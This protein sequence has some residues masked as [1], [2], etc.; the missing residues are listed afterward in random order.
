MQRFFF[1]TNIHGRYVPFVKFR[2]VLA[3]GTFIA[4]IGSAYAQEP[5][6]AA[7]DITPDARATELRAAE[8]LRAEE[9][10]RILRVMPEFNITD[11]Q[12]AAPL[13]SGQKF[14]LALKSDVDPFSFV[15]AGI[16][17][18]IGQAQKES[19]GYGPGMQGYAK[20]FQAA[21]LDSFDGDILGNA[22]FPSLLH[23]DPRYF[24]QGTGSFNSRLMH[25]ISSAWR[26]KNDNGKWTWNYSNLLGNLAAGG[27]ANTYYASADRGAAP[28][29][30]RAL[31][32]TAEG[33]AGSVFYEFWPDI[34]R[35]FLS[36]KKKLQS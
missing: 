29:F 19:P 14:Q 35:K 3:A 4:V 33:A 34:S 10:Q 13:S 25:A 20:R 23:Q 26:C 30:E 9:S 15:V 27:I 31:T 5:G 11:L 8:E 17:A 2:A 24:R 22:V 32:V 12:N 6:T 21:Y 36:K 16:V 1:S 28:T 7:T 18:G